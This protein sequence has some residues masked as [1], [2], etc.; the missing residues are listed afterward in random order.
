MKLTSTLR[1]LLAGTTVFAVAAVGMMTSVSTEKTPYQPRPE[2]PAAQPDGAQEIRRLL[3]GD[4]EGNIDHEGLQSLRE[5]VAK[6]MEKQSRQ[7][8]NSMSWIEL[9][10]DN[11]G[12]R[13]RA[14]VALDNGTLYAGGVSGGLWKSTN[15]GDNWTQMLNFPSLMVGSMAV[16]GDGTMYVGTGSRFDGF[17]SGEGGSE[18]RGEGIWMSTNNGA[19]WTM[20]VGS[21]SYRATDALVADPNQ[22]D[23]VWFGSD[24]AYGSITS[25][26]LAEVPSSSSTPSD[27]TDVAIAPDGSYCLVAASTGRVYRSVGT[28]FTDLQQISQGSGAGGNLPQSSIGRARVDIALTPN[29]DG[30]HNAF[31]LFS[32]PGGLFGGLHYSGGDGLG[33]T[34]SEVW[35]AGITSTPLPR[36]QGYYDLALGISKSDPTLAYVGGIELWRSGP[37]QQAE[38][39][40]APFDAPGITF[41]VHADV[42]EIIFVDDNTTHGTMY[43]ATDGGIYRSED[44]GTTYTACNRDYNVTQFYGMAH[45]AGSGVLGGTQDN[46]SLFIPGDGYF[47]SDQMAVDV[48]GGDGFDCG[49]SMVTEAEGYTY[50]WFAASQNG[51]LVRGTLAPGAISNAGGFY[52]NNFTDLFNDEGELGQFYTCLRLYEDFEDD[53]SKNNVILVNTYGQDSIGGTYTMETNSQN[54]PFAYEMA[55]D[56]TLNFYDVLVRPARV[57]NE[58][59]EEDPDYFWLE[60]QDMTEDVQCTDFVDTLSIDTVW[61]DPVEILL[62]STI[63]VVNELGV[64]V[65][66]DIQ[67]PTGEYDSTMVM[68]VVCYEESEILGYDTL[69]FDITCTTIILDTLD[70]M[71]VY[72]VTETLVDSTVLVVVGDDSLMID[73]EVPVLDSTLTMVPQYLDSLA[74]D[75]LLEVEPIISVYEVC[76]T[77]PMLSYDISS[78]TQCDTSYLYASD[79]LYNIPEQIRVQ[80]PYN[81]MFVLGLN[82]SLGI[83]MTREGLNFNTTPSWIRLADAPPGTGVKA[84]EFVEQGEAKGDVMFY[85][86]WNGSVTRVT[87]LR[88]VYTQEDVNEGALDLHVMLPN[89]GSAVTGLSVDPNDPNHVVVTIGGYST[90]AAG[91]VRETFNALSPD[92]DPATDWSSIW[93]MTGEEASM[94]CY[95]VVIDANDE[96]GQTIVVGTEFGVYVTEDGGSTWNI[97]NLGVES[98]PNGYNA[99]VFDL[100][101]QFRSSHP[102]SNVTNG[103]AIYAGTHGRGM[104]VSGLVTNVEEESAVVNDASAWNVFPNP[105]V[106]GEMNLPTAGWQGNAQ[107]EIFDL[108]GRRWVNEQVQLSGVDRVR[109]DV[110]EL[111][112]GYYVVRMSQGSNF[113]AAKFVVKK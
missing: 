94:P 91:K 110:Q 96:S 111:P 33:G 4:A 32:T 56:D 29:A 108:T 89:A 77:V 36:G 97:S 45:S 53:F 86:G 26:D 6:S 100:K 64:E 43:I 46:G 62:D 109:T 63:L 105:V 87:G 2:R 76:D 74:C 55:A 10:P 60:L 73:V 34:W 88:D 39:A 99:P 13:T 38:P 16:A 69:L 8:A 54:L 24:E 15:R 107:V 17:G 40:A 3:L 103:G 22:S 44:N 78:S 72:V 51:G 19:D 71:E 80:D 7:K 83:W 42:H 49:I 84:I 85:T 67:I 41:G 59:L 11:I 14:I 95:D 112:S 79:T 90:S 18:F 92:F 81:T 113:K 35:P 9:G 61:T 31:A 12:G 48:N 23:R 27:A 50:A 68:D 20:V 98:G 75:T 25:G 102:W 65:E 93:T 47:I 101:Q 1:A 58:P 82:G 5:A 106:S 21:D 37:N 30:T 66:I 104:F 57:T 70:S 28:D 52:D